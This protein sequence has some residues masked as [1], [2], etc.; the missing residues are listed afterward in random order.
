[1]GKSS[2]SFKKGQGG[3]PLGVKNKSY[4]DASHWLERADQEVQ[5]EEDPDKRFSIIKWATELIMPKI[6]SI[7]G[8]PG[9][10]VANAAA[11]HDAINAA[12]EKQKQDMVDKLNADAAGTANSD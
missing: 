11:A 4:L 10:S 7:P 5:K 2:T 8:S 6:P 1:M 3:R 12:I 9:E